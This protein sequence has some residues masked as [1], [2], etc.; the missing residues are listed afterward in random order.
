MKHS[1]SAL[2]K[3]LSG[4]REKLLDEKTGQKEPRRALSILLPLAAI[5]PQEADD[6]LDVLVKL[7]ACH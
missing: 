6:V 7:Q 1:H 4:L 5:L 2:E 3:T